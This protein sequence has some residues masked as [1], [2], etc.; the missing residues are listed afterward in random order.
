MDNLLSSQRVC[1]ILSI[2][3]TTLWRR[4]KSGQIPPPRK[5]FQGAA[6][7]WRESEIE[8]VID[9]L[10]VADAYQ[11]SPPPARDE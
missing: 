3:R 5:A 9:G 8:A 2:S 4:V 6:N 11:T 1:E 7:R 10:A